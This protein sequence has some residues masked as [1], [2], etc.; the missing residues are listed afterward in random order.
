MEG[1]GPRPRAELP[2]QHRTGEAIAGTFTVVGA[3]VGVMV[4]EALHAGHFVYNHI[5]P[6]TQR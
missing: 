2:T 1:I 5:R 4:V 3:A 6:H